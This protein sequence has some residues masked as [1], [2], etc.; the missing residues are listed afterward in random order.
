MAVF[1]FVRLQRSSGRGDLEYGAWEL[2]ELEVCLSGFFLFS[3]MHPLKFMFNLLHVFLFSDQS[4]GWF[5]SSSGSRGKNQQ[6]LLSRIQ[7]WTTFSSLNRWLWIWDFSSLSKAEQ[8]ML[9]HFGKKSL[10]S[11]HLRSYCVNGFDTEIKRSNSTQKYN[12]SC[13]MWPPCLLINYLK[14]EFGVSSL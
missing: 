7:G 1:V 2:W 9:C 11:T 8:I 10:Q 4:T 6:D 12:T 5:F 13:I 3:C 14:Y